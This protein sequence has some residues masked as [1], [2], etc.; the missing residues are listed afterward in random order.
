MSVVV[1]GLNH[2][3]VPLA[4]LEPMT[5]LPAR[6]PKALH[7]LSGSDHI[8]EVVLVSTCMRT[9]IYAVASRYHNAIH[10]IREFIGT[11]SGLPPE[12]WSDHAYSYHDEA[13]VKHLFRVAAG[14]DSAVLG[15]GEI[16]RQVRTSWEAAHTEEVDGPILAMLFRLAA[17]TGKRVRA[18]TLI[19]HGTTSLSHAA[20]AMASERLGSLAGRTTLLVGAGEMGEAMATALAAS[21]AAGPVLVANRTWARATALAAR[22]GGGAVQWDALP[23]AFET[24]DV[25][26]TST[27]SPDFLIDA[28]DLE[29]VLLSRGG[30]P[31]LIVD[32]AVPRDVDPS[33]GSLPGVT[34]LDMDDLKRFAEDA[35]DG[36]RQEVPAAE[37][38]V[39]EEIDRYLDAA[40]QRQVAPVVATLHERGE[41][42]RQSEL[43]RLES[44]LADLDPKS[45]RAVEALSRGIV[46]KL[47]HEP[48]VNV[49]A[50]AGSPGGEQLASALRQLFD[51]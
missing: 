33:V 41:V 31:L 35:M 17:E 42:I 2:R 47:L 34:V 27:G 10:D 32:I 21:P 30:R 38:I 12:A 20:V 25:L 18:E 36:R 39:A 15:E 40:T 50:A 11:W 16:L 19:T 3:T 1:V 23:E 4:L 29:P 24:A 14:L 9:E 37:R 44:R 26:L 6:L 43:A 5:V 13:A 48:T 22:C 51:L 7:E 45:R 46:A 8:A 28:T 49:K